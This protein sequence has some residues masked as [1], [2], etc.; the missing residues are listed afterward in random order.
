MGD[1]S[2][3]QMWRGG[4]D[5]V[6]PK[7]SLV[8]WNCGP[9]PTCL[10]ANAELTL[11]SLISLENG[12]GTAFVGRSACPP[13]AGGRCGLG[14][15]SRTHRNAGAGCCSIEERDESLKKMGFYPLRGRI[16]A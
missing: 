16:G 3:E 8:P 4:S 10:M 5:I 2:P 12:R 13:L 9:V 7:C 14:S 6:S 11:I 15:G 1:R